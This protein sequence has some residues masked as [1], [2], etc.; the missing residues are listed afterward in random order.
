LSLPKLAKATVENKGLFSKSALRRRK[1][2]NTALRGDDPQWLTEFLSRAWEPTRKDLEALEV[3][4]GPFVQKFKAVYEPI[5]H[6][7][8]AHRSMQDETVVYQLF[9]NALLEDVE[10]IMCFV[11][12]FHLAIWEL[13]WNG[14]R[15]DLTDSSSYKSHVDI[16]TSEFE[17]FIRQLA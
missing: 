4:L 1:R 8:Y 14:K 17:R 15:P 13:A 9:N 3:A 6:Q 12:T 10:A 16:L 7:I 5:R 2:Q 11:H